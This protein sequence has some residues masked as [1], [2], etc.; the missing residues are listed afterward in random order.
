MA[1]RHAGRV[2]ARVV[3]TLV[4]LHAAL[5]VAAQSG[6]QASRLR[7]MAP[8]NR[9]MQL[10]T[11]AGKASVVTAAQI[12]ESGQQSPAFQHPSD[13]CWSALAAALGR[14]RIDEAVA[15]ARTGCIKYV[16]ADYCQF[17]AELDS[18]GSSWDPTKM[19]VRSPSLVAIA[20]ALDAVDAWVIEDAEVGVFGRANGL[21][22]PVFGPVLNR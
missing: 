21:V 11:P 12:C 3:G 22:L 16:R 15:Q 10:P 19:T 18:P 2:A 17:M 14:G 7:E 5:P 4:A 9:A 20:R 13:A 8:T 1:K 6:G